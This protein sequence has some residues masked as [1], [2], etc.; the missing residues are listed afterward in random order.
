[1]G[2]VKSFVLRVVN[3]DHSL[4]LVL[5]TKRTVNNKYILTTYLYR[6]KVL[7]SQN[8]RMFSGSVPFVNNLLR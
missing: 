3:L 2:L 4:H 7:V 6:W 8:K 1:M 5:S